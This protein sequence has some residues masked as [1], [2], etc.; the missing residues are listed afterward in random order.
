MADKAQVT[1]VEAI[2]AF[3][4]QLVVYLAQMRP[5][6]DEISSEV[7]HT[8]SW[9]QDDRRRHWQQEYRLRSRKLED[10]RQE[11]F[12]AS[13]S[14]MGD[15][16]SSQQMDLQRAQ[17]ELRLVEEK[18]VVLKRWDHNLENQTAPLVKQMEQLHAFLTVEM[19]RAVAYLDQA[20]RALDAYR[21]VARPGAGTSGT[22]Q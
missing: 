22:S 8:R 6:L 20:I 3:R 7:L 17:R 5:T 19:E 4:A 2:E 1:S 10:A 11:L 9:L 14:M 12:T 15:A 18:L 16:K 21:D 13:I